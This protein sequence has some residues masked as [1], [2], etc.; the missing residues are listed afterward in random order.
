MLPDQKQETSFLHPALSRYHTDKT[1]RFVLFLENSRSKFE[2]LGRESEAK[3]CRCLLWLEKLAQKVAGFHGMQSTTLHHTS[4]HDRGTLSISFWR[5]LSKDA[6]STTSAKLMLL[7]GGSWLSPTLPLGKSPVT[8]LGRPATPSPSAEGC[9][10]RAIEE[11]RLPVQR[12]KTFFF[13]SSP[14]HLGKVK[15]MRALR[16]HVLLSVQR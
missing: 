13:A 10:R 9:M 15:T 2:K 14:P 8:S 3:R 4:T 16:H 5:R 11:A 7:V 6:S 12:R 1:R